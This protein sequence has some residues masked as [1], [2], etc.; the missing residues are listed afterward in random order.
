MTFNPWLPDEWQEIRFR[1]RWRGN[2]VQVAVGHAEATFTLNDPE[3]VT[4]QIV[5]GAETVTLVSNRPATVRLSD[6][7]PTSQT[8]G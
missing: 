1:L 6:V 8:F 7:E 2:S 3:G 5:V 4:E